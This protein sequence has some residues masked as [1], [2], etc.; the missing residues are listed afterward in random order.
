MPFFV[1]DTRSSATFIIHEIPDSATN[2]IDRMQ[3]PRKIANSGP[4]SLL[5]I[6]K[7]SKAEGVLKKRGTWHIP[8][9]PIG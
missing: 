1:N 5:E 8:C 2:I 3:A 6:N 4:I 7:S 9:Y